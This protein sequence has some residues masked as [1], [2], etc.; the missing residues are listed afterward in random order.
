MKLSGAG[1]PLTAIS[2]MTVMSLLTAL[3]IAVGSA[4]AQGLTAEEAEAA[5]EARQS[6]FRQLGSNMDPMGEMLRNRQPFDPERIAESAQR[7]AELAPMIPEAFQ[8]DTRGMAVTTQA[9]DGIWNSM[10]DFRQRSVQLAASASELAT[11]AEG[12]D[13][14]A[15][16]RAIGALGQVCGGCHDAYR[17]Q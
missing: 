4:S 5:A 14:A 11:I 1:R 13:R 17:S 15:I 3:M 12:G 7:I 6:V 16:G 2:L 8:A 9:R 10:D